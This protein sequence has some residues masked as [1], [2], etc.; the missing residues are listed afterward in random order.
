LL[1]RY[2]KFFNFPLAIL[3]HFKIPKIFVKQKEG[4]KV[5]PQELFEVDPPDP[6]VNEEIAP[7]VFEH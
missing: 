4:L 3:F 5:L 1:E 7:I 2:L 6:A